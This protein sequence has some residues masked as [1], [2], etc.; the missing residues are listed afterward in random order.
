MMKWG[1]LQNTE[2]KTWKMR[3]KKFSSFEVGSML[4]ILEL[5]SF[6]IQICWWDFSLLNSKTEERQEIRLTEAWHHYHQ[7]SFLTCSL[8]CRQEE[9]IEKK[10][11]CY[12]TEAIFKYLFLYSSHCLFPHF[13]ASLK[14]F[15]ITAFLREFYMHLQS[16]RSFGGWG[17]SFLRLAKNP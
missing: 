11:G 4:H 6:R 7:Q 12:T 14:L 13:A 10:R 16:L 15:T 9:V 2:F 17:G 3:A 8:P 1:S 5:T